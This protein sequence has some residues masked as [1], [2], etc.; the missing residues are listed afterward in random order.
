[1]QFQ[2]QWKKL[3]HAPWHKCISNVDN[4]LQWT[5]VS[6]AFFWW[7]KLVLYFLSLLMCE[8]MFEPISA[9]SDA[10]VQSNRPR[11]RIWRCL[12]Q[13]AVRKER[14]PQPQGQPYTKV[15]LV[16]VANTWM[17]LYT[18]TNVWILRLMTPGS[19]FMVHWC[20]LVRVPTLH[21]RFEGLFIL[22]SS[23]MSFNLATLLQPTSTS[24]STLLLAAIPAPEEARRNP[25]KPP[26]NPKK[27]NT[28][29]HIVFNI[30]HAWSL[31]SE[32]SNNFNYHQQQTCILPRRTLLPF[33]HSKY[34][35]E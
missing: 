21:L 9:H 24:T 16:S 33:C 23:I 6:L 4:T 14:R 15:W 17:M 35:P 2:K 30:K 29:I 13:S 5:C 19:S 3:R 8:C 26:K 12:Y 1:M 28:P 11:R 22:P 10:T 18:K 27:P 7:Y 25:K 31:A 34:L 32:H 20:R